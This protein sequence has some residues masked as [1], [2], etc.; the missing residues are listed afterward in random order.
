MQVICRMVAP[1]NCS[2]VKQELL[3]FKNHFF[4]Q[5][6]IA[7]SINEWGILNSIYL[8][9]TIFTTIGEIIFFQIIIVC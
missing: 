7:P 4:D 3:N 2:R 9:G 8:C 5:Y 6:D 1:S